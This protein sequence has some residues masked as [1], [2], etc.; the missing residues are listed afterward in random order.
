[1]FSKAIS[2]VQREH[3]ALLIFVIIG[4]VLRGHGLFERSLWFDEVFSVNVS[5]PANSLNTVFQLTVEDVHPPLYQILL[6]LVHQV[7]GYGERVGRIFSLVLSVAVIPSMY[8]LGAALFNRRV[9][10]IAALLSTVSFILVV[11]AQET[12][13]YSLLVLL[14]VWSLLMFFN[15]LETQNFRTVLLYSVVGSMLVNTHYFG[16]IP[17]AA[18]FFLLIYFSIRAGFERRLFSASAIAGLLICSSLIPLFQYLLKNFG[19]T[20]TWIKKPAESFFIDMFVVQFGSLP[21]VLLCLFLLVLALVK[22][23]RVQDKKDV[24]KVLLFCWFFGVTVAY[25]RSLFFTPIL[26]LKNAM[27]FLPITIVLVSYGFGLVRDGFVRWT[28]LIFVCGVSA[29]FVLSDPDRSQFRIESDLRSPVKK[30][31]EEGRGLPVYANSVYSDYLQ[32]LGS[33]VRTK[34]FE[35]LKRQLKAGSTGPCFYVIDPDADELSS[36]SKQLDTMVVEKN[37]Y[38]QSSIALL[39]S[40]DGA[41]CISRR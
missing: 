12:R 33:S 9:G 4:G 22:L 21:V 2:V 29:S 36:Y 10:V 15:L 8:C 41:D 38:Q 11:E 28:M 34:S 7:F 32:I 16:F 1:M 37:D 39:K 3:V 18:Q 35:E 13:S 5:N 19:R 40:R 26:T 20:G 27:V 6:W 30:V 14:M 25:L 17:M 24:L 23:F 31:M